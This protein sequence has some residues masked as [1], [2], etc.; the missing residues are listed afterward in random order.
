M[1]EAVNGEIRNP[2]RLI[3]LNKICEKYGIEL[4][5]PNRL[6]YK[7][8]WLAGVVDSDG[9]IIMNEKS[10]QMRVTVSK[11]NKLI[12]DLLPD[13]YGGRVYVEKESFK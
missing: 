12:L 5:Q 9:S 1:I 4:K 6:E 13:L 10:S 7:N 8:G 2:V 3:E 11:K